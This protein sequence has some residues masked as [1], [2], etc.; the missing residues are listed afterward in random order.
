MKVVFAYLPILAWQTIVWLLVIFIYKD[1]DSLPVHRD[2]IFPITDIKIVID[3]DKPCPP[4]PQVDH[5]SRVNL[6]RKNEQGAYGSPPLPFG[7]LGRGVV[8]LLRRKDPLL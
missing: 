6:Y 8:C 2:F 3:L 5:P 1:L 7:F 4:K